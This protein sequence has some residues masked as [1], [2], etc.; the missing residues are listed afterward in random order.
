MLVARYRP[1]VEQAPQQE[2]LTL[3][4]VAS[5]LGVPVSKLYRLRASGAVTFP[6]FWTPEA[7]EDAREQ[8][9]QHRNRRRSQQW[10]GRNRSRGRSSQWIEARDETDHLLKTPEVAERLGMTRSA[11]GVAIHDGRITPPAINLGRGRGMGY[12]WTQEEV[13]RAARELQG[14]RRDLGGYLVW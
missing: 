1:V 9:E 11:L 10:V 7:V 8:I 3:Q 2:Q 12:R 14:R 5:R 4:E 13:Q 6:L